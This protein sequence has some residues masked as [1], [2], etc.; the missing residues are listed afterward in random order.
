MDIRAQRE[1]DHIIDI[2][3]DMVIDP[4]RYYDFIETC[5][6]SLDDW[7]DD[8][9]GS[10]ATLM[11]HFQRASH[12]IER[13]AEVDI[14]GALQ[15]VVDREMQPA[16]ILTATS[17]LLHVN[18]ATRAL[19]GIQAG[20]NLMDLDFS[21]FVNDEISMVTRQLCSRDK[22]A[23][24]KPKVFRVLH[25]KTQ[26]TLLLSIVPVVQKKGDT[27]VV[28]IKTTDII[29]PDTLT[30]S[31]M[32][33]F[34][35]TEAECNIVRALVEG[36]NL[37]HIAAHRGTSLK[38]VRTQLRNIFTKTMTNSQLDLLRMAIGFVRLGEETDQA[39]TRKPVPLQDATTYFGPGV[40]KMYTHEIGQEFEFLHYGKKTK[41]PVLVFHDE[42]MGDAFLYPFF[43]EV[44]KDQTSFLLP[45]RPGYGRSHIKGMSA[46]Q[47]PRKFLKG[48]KAYLDKIGIVGPLKI[49][50]RG[51]GYYFAA[52]FGTMYPQMCRA[53]VALSP[54]LPFVE[55]HDFAG[56]PKYQK[57]I[58]SVGLLGPAALEFS[59]RA[60]LLAYMKSDRDKFLL[61][62]YGDVE[63][64]KP[65][66]RRAETR[67]A[68]KMGGSMTLTQ[69]YI[70][71]LLDE[72]IVQGDWTNV[73]Q[74]CDIPVHM[75]I[76][77]E[78]K[79]SRILRGQRV[80][81][82][83]NPIRLSLIPNT[84]YLVSFKDFQHVAQA[85]SEG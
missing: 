45:V 13:M 35:L 71:L 73:I 23:E 80:A 44:T 74:A 61:H 16:F 82:L 7:A 78:D 39:T 10:Y 50:T 66:L 3:Y 38:T 81:R 69:G 72:K 53:I 54:S 21:A 42:L 26:K 41:T 79:P 60:G 68:M 58:S 62:L 20:Q 49:I 22:D 65:L 70:G 84:G 64:D 19:Y 76:G 56:M 2:V 34:N 14:A 11:H 59:I 28:L 31:F 40:S 5:R 30:R 67:N 47:T 29:W 15:S 25:S 12:M 17:T 83:S 43:S 48:V 55:Q 75:I 4:G 8:K 46:T 32:D 51:N 6:D 77:A 36:Q 37:K 52:L 24:R 63:A 85:L 27:P 9:N 57:F 18:A 1:E 33:V